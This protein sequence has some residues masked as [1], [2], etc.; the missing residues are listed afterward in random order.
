[1]KSKQFFLIIVFS[2][3]LSTSCN[4][5]CPGFDTK[6]LEWMPY[7]LND[8]IIYYN[9]NNDTISF[10]INQK[11]ISSSYETS[12]KNRKECVSEMSIGEASSEKGLGININKKSDLIIISAAA[13]INSNS[14]SIYLET[15]NIENE[16]QTLTINNKSFTETIMFE[17]DTTKN[18]MKIWKIIIAKNYGIVQ[19][20]DRE[21]DEIWTL[22]T[23]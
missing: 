4:Y 3:S 8:K 5:N 14:G 12:Y 17:I 1:M 6:L 11:D 18:D 15:E 16:T 21:T 10:T 19:F 7:D 20:F 2:I 22:Q 13:R 23:D 9:Q